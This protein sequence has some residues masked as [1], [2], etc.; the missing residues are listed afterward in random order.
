MLINVPRTFYFSV[1]RPTN[2]HNE[3]RHTARHALTL[4]TYD[5]NMNVQTV[6]TATTQSDF[7]GTV[8]T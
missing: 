8:A 2:T 3:T 1:P 7:M 5:S 4:S 6:Y